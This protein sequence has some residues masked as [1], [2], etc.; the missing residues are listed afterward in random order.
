MTL[1]GKWSA[2]EKTAL[3]MIFYMGG[4][5]FALVGAALLCFQREIFKST[6]LVIPTPVPIVVTLV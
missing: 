1:M 5:L 4:F 3:G 2:A 6:G